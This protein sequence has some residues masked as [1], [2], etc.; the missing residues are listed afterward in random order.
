M[1]L[2]WFGLACSVSL[3]F[4]EVYSLTPATGVLDKTFRFEPKRLTQFA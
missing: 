4:V 2:S 1:V 3:R